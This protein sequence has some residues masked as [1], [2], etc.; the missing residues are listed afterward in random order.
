M[1]WDI[2]LCNDHGYDD[3]VLWDTQLCDDLGY[4]DTQC[5]RRQRSHQDI[6]GFVC[7]DRGYD[8]T[9]LSDI[10]LCNDHGYDETQCCGRQRSINKSPALFVMIMV[11][12]TQCCGTFSF[13]MILVMM[14]HSVVEDSGPSR[15]RQLCV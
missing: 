14:T 13:V 15:H 2:Q 11:M 1:L 5:C 7:D 3:T 6:V 12:M 8:D 9:V 10:Q 4:D